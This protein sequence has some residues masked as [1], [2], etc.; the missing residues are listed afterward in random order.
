MSDTPAAALAG[1]IVRTGYETNAT[2]A[3]D[4]AAAILAALPPGWCGHDARDH[5][6]E[7]YVTIAT[8][9]ARLKRSIRQL[10]DDLPTQRGYPDRLGRFTRDHR[11]TLVELDPVIDAL[12]AALGEEGR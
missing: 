7:E 10:R 4:L 3:Q 2:G 12:S 5:W 1:A 11:G 9:I 8:E 6:Y